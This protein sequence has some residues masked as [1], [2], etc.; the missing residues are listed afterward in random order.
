MFLVFIG[1]SVK[2]AETEAFAVISLV[3]FGI[4]LL[5]SLV[6]LIFSSL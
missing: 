6:V 3:V 1:T 4:C 5:L 2:T